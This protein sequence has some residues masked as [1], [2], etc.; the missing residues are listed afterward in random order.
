MGTIW[1]DE[2]VQV[3]TEPLVSANYAFTRNLSPAMHLN[4]AV[5]GE[6]EYDNTQWTELSIAAVCQ[7]VRLHGASGFGGGNP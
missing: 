7:H 1:P 5:E 6:R 2:L 4:D 3:K